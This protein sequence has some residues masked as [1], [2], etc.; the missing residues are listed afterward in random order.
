VR[1]MSGAGRSTRLAKLM[2]FMESFGTSEGWE[3]SDPVCYVACVMDDDH[4]LDPKRI[5]RLMI[6]CKH[7]LGP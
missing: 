7:M 3:G 5:V 1:R 2:H 4:N 6:A